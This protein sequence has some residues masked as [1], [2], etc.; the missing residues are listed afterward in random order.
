MRRRTE[1]P[2]T[3]KARAIIEDSSGRQ[4]EQG[5]RSRRAE[6]PRDAVL[7]RLSGHPLAKD[8]DQQ[9]ARADHERDPPPNSCRWGV[10]KWSIL[11]Q[12]GCRTTALHRGIHMVDQALH[13]YAAALSAAGHANRS[14]RL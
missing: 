4:D 12:P 5:S 11:P 9:S 13:E 1:P 8:P 14:R 10:P 6:R 7:L 3:E 2:P